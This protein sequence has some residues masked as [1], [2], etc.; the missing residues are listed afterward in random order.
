MDKKERI[1]KKINNYFFDHY[2]QQTII[3]YT[4]M[5]IL[6]GISG[7]IFAFG[8]STFITSYSAGSM[9]LATGGFSGFTQS[10][11]L[12]ISLTSDKL[13]KSILQSILY[14]VFNIPAIVFAY[15]KIGKR[16]AITT[17]I[18]V[19]LGSLFI[20]IFSNMGLIQEIANNDFISKSSLSRVLFAGICTGVSSGIAFK[21]G[22][23]CGG[24]DIVTG[25]LSL[26]KSTGVGK[27]NIYANTAVIIFYLVCNLIATP[28]KY[29]E[30][31][32]IVPFALVYF[33][34]SSLVI[35]VIH[36]RNKK[37]SVEI[38]TSVDYMSDILVSIFPHSC[39]LLEGKGAYSKADKH[40]IKMVVSSYETKKIVKY[41]KRIDP[42]AFIT[43]VPLNQVYG[44]FF[45]NPVE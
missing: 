40:I 20:S 18:N 34:V 28:E 37:I 24:M 6:A 19:A 39:T 43:L 25:Y 11:V 35:D 7:I 42:D 4:W 1:R 33:L 45:I 14:F 32:L 2:I 10:I 12:L 31:I 17:T 9:P 23:S 16:F 22:S 5:T 29:V 41:I 8:F 36:V 13:D 21:G 3:N 44:N 27:Y 30:A 26:K 15:F 38:I